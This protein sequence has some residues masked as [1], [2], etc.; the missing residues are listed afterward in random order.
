[1]SRRA[2]L[3]QQLA[4]AKFFSLLFDGSTDKANIDN[5]VVLVVWCEHDEADEKVCTRMEY[6]TVVRPQSVTAQGLFES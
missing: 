6:L 4:H 1:M 5:E 2:E 3:K